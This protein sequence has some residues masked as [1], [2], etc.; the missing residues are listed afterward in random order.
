MYL[1]LYGWEI[2]QKLPINEFEWIEDIPEFDER[3]IKRL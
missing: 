2:S 3:L 1:N